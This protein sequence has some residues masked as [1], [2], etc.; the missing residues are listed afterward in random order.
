MR[1]SLNVN[2]SEILRQAALGGMGLALLAGWLIRDNLAADAN[3]G[4]MDL[5]IHAVYPASRRCSAKIRVFTEMLAVMLN[6]DSRG[7]T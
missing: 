1:G 7:D 6:D 2:N 5:V 4:D 3:P